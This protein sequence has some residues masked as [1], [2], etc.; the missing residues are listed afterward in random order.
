MDPDEEE[1]AALRMSLLWRPVNK[2][3][4]RTS[5]N[6]YTALCKTSYRNLTQMI[7]LTYDYEPKRL[8]HANKINIQKQNVMATKLYNNVH[9]FEI[10]INFF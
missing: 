9:D 8:Y 5:D 2:Q 3:Q 4:L 1:W 7:P 6:F 10:I